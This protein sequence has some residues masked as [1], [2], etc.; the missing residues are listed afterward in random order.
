MSCKG[1][2]G[3]AKRKCL[4]KGIKYT[5]LEQAKNATARA[6]NKSSNASD[7]QATKKDSSDYKSGYRMGMQRQNPSA[8]SHPYGENEYQKMGRWEGQNKKKKK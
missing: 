4:E 3:D 1:L 8:S 2:T 7:A 6:N 5:M